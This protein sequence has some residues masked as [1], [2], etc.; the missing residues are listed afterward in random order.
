MQSHNFADNL[1]VT[2]MS[3]PLRKLCVIFLQA[4]HLNFFTSDPDDKDYVMPDA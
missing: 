4:G 1:P 2:S 3:F